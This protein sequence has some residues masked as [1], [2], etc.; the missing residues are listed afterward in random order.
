MQ[1]KENGKEKTP[2][3]DNMCYMYRNWW[4][5]NRK[6]VYFCALRVPVLVLLPMITALLPKLMIDGITNQVTPGRLVAMVAMGSVAIAGL[7]W[8]SPF[9]EE[10][11]H[12]I[13]ETTRMNY[14]VMAFHKVLHTDYE[15]IESLEGRLKFEKSKEFAFGGRWS[16]SQDFYDVSVQLA[17]N[18]MG[19]FAYLVLLSFL[20]PLMVLLILLTC[21]FEYLIMRYM[22]KSEHNVWKDMMPLFM[23]F[24]YLYRT[25]LDVESGKD[26]RM[27]GADLWFLQIIAEAAAKHTKFMNRLA[28][29]TLRMSGLG[30]LLAMARELTAYAF[31]INGVLNGSMTVADFIFY[32]GIV[33]GFSAW[34]LGMAW[35]INDL[36][37]ACFQCQQFRN[38]LDIPERK[39]TEVQGDTEPLATPE[40]IEFRDVSFYY[41]KDSEPVLQNVS[42]KVKRGEKIAI[43]GENG[44]GKTTLIKILCGFYRPTEGQV[45]VDGAD[46]A[47]L[48]RDAYFD[49]FSAVFQDFNFLP[50]SITQNI[51]LREEA[52]VDSTR[53][54]RTLEAVGLWEKISALAEGAKSKMV[55]Q[56]YENAEDFSGGEKQRL[57]LARALYKNAPV[58]VLDE[59]TAALDPIAENRLYEQYDAL[60]GEKTSFFISH[61]LSSTR[62]CERIFYMANGA[63]TE[64]GTHED[65]LARQGAY[66]RMYETQS[67]YYLLQEEA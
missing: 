54:E 58:L 53:V 15:N 4:A 28:G 13:A 25:A 17:A 45:L 49:L 9:L 39:T 55:K 64:E 44:A 23:R 33:T 41:D 19:I 59:P 43:V 31:L 1:E 30:A 61:R 67:Y 62:F 27:Y 36:D 22:T 52:D 51:A 60:M 42:F 2:I 29:Q 7:S 47:S 34:I 65:L 48:H 20:Q 26:V 56:V 16:G 35:Q 14:R 50:M 6:S 46:A 5:W 57:L 18:F 24:D 10:K 63:I 3:V 11:I 38:F 12:A 40:E 32:F 37:S 66:W 21:V 8:V